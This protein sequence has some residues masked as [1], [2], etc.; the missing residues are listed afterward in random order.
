M[1]QTTPTGLT[2]IS[3]DRETLD[4]VQ[5]YLERAGAR[6][7]TTSRLDEAEDTSSGADAVVFFADDY[8]LEESDI[9]LAGLAVR[10]LVIVT[11]EIA[12][13][14]ARRGSWPRAERVVVLPRPAW[15]WVLLD[16]V[17]HGL[18]DRGGRA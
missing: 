3:A 17:R 11:A 16:A 7:R 13:F 9:I 10:L 4:G 12:A 8:S 18:G 1:F 2:L 5:A 15:G 14:N 6:V